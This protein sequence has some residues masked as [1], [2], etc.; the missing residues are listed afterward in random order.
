VKEQFFQAGR[1]YEEILDRKD[2]AIAVYKQLHEYDA[3]DLTALDKLIELYLGQQSWNELL[4]LYEKKSDLVQDVEEKKRILLETGSVFRLEVKDRQRAIDCYK[5]IIELDP[6]DL[7]AI[8]QLDE[9]YEETESWHELLHVL[10]R[11]ADVATEPNDVLAFRFR[12]GRLWEQKLENVPKAIEFY[13]GILD[14]NPEH[15]PS[16]EALEVL[17]TSGREALAA[18]AVLAPLYESMG[19]WRKLIATH[20]VEIGKTDD[21]FRQVEL[22]HRVAELYERPDKLNEPESAFTAFARAFRIDL[23]NDHT[24]E[25]LERLAQM[26]DTWPKLAALYDEGVKAAKEPEAKVVLGLRAARL[27]EEEVGQP[28]QAIE[29][30]R[31]VLAAEP[32]NA[33]ALRGLDRLYRTTSAWKE[34]VEILKREEGIAEN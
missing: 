18:A 31:G 29:R 2:R 6:A 5:R 16:I 20:A 34:L 9:L 32:E 23:L 11:E 24:L 7:Q 33:S 25:A 14:A 4:A 12:S 19:E 8:A 13:R 26:L 30:L 3:E 1:I 27:Y 22:L 28:P 21:V 17:M 15:L 10:E